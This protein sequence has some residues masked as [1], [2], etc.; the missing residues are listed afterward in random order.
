MYTC[1]SGQTAFTGRGR[2]TAAIVA[3]LHD[4][5]ELLP[6]LRRFHIATKTPAEPLRQELGVAKSTKE[7]YEQEKATICIA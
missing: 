1:V 4:F 2:D 3:I 7:T 6:A 5:A